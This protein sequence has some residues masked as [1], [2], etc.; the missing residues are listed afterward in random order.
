MKIKNITSNKAKQVTY[1]NF[2][3]FKNVFFKTNIYIYTY[4]FENH[5]NKTRKAKG[6]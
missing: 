5:S 4:N 3:V 2:Q 6:L 1:K